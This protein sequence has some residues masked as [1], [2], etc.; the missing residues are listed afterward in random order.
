MNGKKK[1]KGEKT[2]RWFLFKGNKVGLK[3]GEREGEGEARLSTDN[4]RHTYTYI[5]RYT[6]F[7][8]PQLCFGS[9][10]VYV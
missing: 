2:G 8:R 9:T 6:F 5:N 4:G 10:F 7:C 3:A 1:R